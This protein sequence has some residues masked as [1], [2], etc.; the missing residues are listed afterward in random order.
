MVKPAR[1]W[2]NEDVLQWMN[3]LGE[4]VKR[5]CMEVFEKEVGV[6]LGVTSLEQSL[7]YDV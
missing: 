6:S 3:G 5:E 2:S 4:T 7:M 1:E